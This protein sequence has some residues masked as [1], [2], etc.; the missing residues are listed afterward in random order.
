MTV[1]VLPFN[2]GPNTKPALARQFA[3]FACEIVRQHCEG[4]VN[5]VSYMVRLDGEPPRYANVNPSE[6]L[7]ESEIVQQFF[8]QAEIEQIMDG[9]LVETDGTF[10]LTYRFFSQGS[11]EPTETKDATFAAKECFGPI[12]QEVADLSA[13]AGKQL[14]AELNTDEELFGTA[15]PE[16]FLLFLEGFDALQYIERAQGQVATEFSSEPALESL[17]AALRLDVDW[18]GPYVTL[19]QLC[20]LS[21]QMRI[22]NADQMEAVLKQAIELVPD[23]GRAYFALG[24][25]YEATQNLPQA[26]EAFEKSIQREPN[27]SAIY[28]RLGLVQMAQGMPVNA[29]RNFRKAV[30]MEGD[31]KPSMDF[32]AGVLG[33]TGRSHEVPALWKELVEKN[34]ANAQAHA[35]LAMSLIQNGQEEEGIRAF[36]LAL[37]TLEDNTL[38][39]RYYAPFLAQKGEYDQAMDF[40]EDCLDVTP[41]DVALLIEYAQ[42]LQAGGR[43][44]EIP[45]V[46]KTILDANPDPNTRAQTLAWMIEL[47]QPKRVEAVQEAQKLMEAEDF[48]GAASLLR[49]MKNWLADYWKMWALLSAALNRI[50]EHQEAEEAAHRL[51]DLFPGCEPAYGEL[52]A[53]LNA[54]GRDEDAYNSM[55]FAASMIQGSLPIA[56]NLALTAKRV[57]NL[58]EARALA[59]QIREAVGPNEE[60]EPVL[61]EIEA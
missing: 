11:T 21:T 39:K 10:H 42:T 35:K 7:N 38:I 47:E 36:D 20:R 46:L 45:A 4:D 58:D 37:E 19:V 33:Q 28:T 15:D 52:V 5:S 59:K 2:A 31:D 60:L 17:I 3:N 61:A 26:A 12:R 48:Q 27:E 50:G 8:Q 56:V 24:E 29:E 30:E 6:A 32:L 22:G 18:E 51:I 1:A 57:G 13:R 53:A 16:A 23:D 14:P 49:P 40:Y 34:A 25:L 55:R 9:L 54:Q 43:T 41:T 44:V